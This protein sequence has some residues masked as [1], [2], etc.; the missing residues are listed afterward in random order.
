MR[1]IALVI[2][3]ACGSRARP[4]VVET[5]GASTAPGPRE[6]LAVIPPDAPE[7]AGGALSPGAIGHGA[8]PVPAPPPAA[9]AP[10]AQPNVNSPPP[11]SE[12]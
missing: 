12:P 7:Q 2:L 9:P 6:A 4:P 5:L 11:P 1:I 8:A 10:D 3:A